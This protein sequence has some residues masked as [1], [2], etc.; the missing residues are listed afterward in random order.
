MFEYQFYH[1]CTGL[2]ILKVNVKQKLVVYLVMLLMC[3]ASALVVTW[4]RD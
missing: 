1:V 2:V 4:L 3:A